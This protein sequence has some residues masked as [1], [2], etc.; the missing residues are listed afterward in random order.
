MSLLLCVLL[1]ALLVYNDGQRKDMSVCQMILWGLLFLA[2]CGSLYDGREW[3]HFEVT[4]WK[5]TCL[6]DGAGRC[7]Q[8]CERGF[9][10][11]GQAHFEYSGDAERM[12]GCAAAMDDGITEE[13]ASGGGCG[14]G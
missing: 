4:P 12:L 9:N 13:Y 11:G 10:G 7:P 1:L 6:M 14:C 2:V 8:C 5:K 3:F